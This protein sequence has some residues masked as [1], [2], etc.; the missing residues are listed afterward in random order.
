MSNWGDIFTNRSGSIEIK[1][2]GFNTSSNDNSGTTDLDNYSKTILTNFT[3][4]KWK[5][6]SI[7][8]SS[9][10]SIALGCKS[11]DF[12]EFSLDGTWHYDV[13]QNNCN[14]ST[15]NSNGT[16][17]SIPSCKPTI[18]ETG[19]I[20][21]LN[22]TFNPTASFYSASELAFLVTVGQ[23]QHSYHFKK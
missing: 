15:T 20:T 5:L 7:K 8:N 11:D 21:H 4:G 10:N 23:N 6:T 17:N 14:G 1:Y 12:I 3:S 22:G 19:W 13:G 16:Y 2:S 9:S 18:Y